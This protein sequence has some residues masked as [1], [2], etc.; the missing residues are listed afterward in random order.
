MTGA[1]DFK[2][3]RGDWWVTPKGCWSTSATALADWKTRS[4]FLACPLCG[5]IG[6]LPHAV[7]ADGLVSPSVVCPNVPKCQMHLMP[8]RLLEWDLGVKPSDR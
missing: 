7:D 1:Y 3:W 8:V 5:E 6:G 4:A 2:R